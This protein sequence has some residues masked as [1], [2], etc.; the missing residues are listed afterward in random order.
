MW[1]TLASDPSASIF[2]SADI[3]ISL[4]NGGFN[5]GGVVW[6]GHLPAPLLGVPEIHSV[7]ANKIEI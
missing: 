3:L 5:V 2:F 4:F 7:N 6:A 1:I